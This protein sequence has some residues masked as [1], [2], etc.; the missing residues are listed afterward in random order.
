MF[1]RIECGRRNYLLPLMRLT[2]IKLAGFKS[3]VDPTSIATPGQLIGIVGPNG[4]GKSNVID[5]VRWVLGE[6]SAKQLRG[7]S[8]A[9][10]IFSGSADRKPL[11]RASVELVF[12]NLLGRLSGPW[13]QYTE[14]SVKRIVTREGDSSY[15]IN[16]QHV[17]RKDVT[18]LFLGT[19]LG[20]RS[21]AI[22]EQ[23]MIS[24]V[25][26]AKPEE[27]R[28]FLEEAAGVSKYRERRRETESRLEDTREN[29]SRVADILNELDQ[30]LVKLASQAEVAAKFNELSGDLKENQN[31]YT[32]TRAREA[33]QARERYANEVSKIGVAI[34]AEMAKLR[35]TERLLT[36]LRESH[37]GEVEKLQGLQGAMF[38]ANSSVSQLQQEL[39][40]LTDNRARLT[41]QVEKLA[42]EAAR[43]GMQFTQTQTDNA[44]WSNEL[45][46]SAERIETAQMLAEEKHGL[47]PAAEEAHLKSQ[48]AAK[49]AEV[50]LR[51]AEQAQ[52]MDEMREGQA[53]KNIAQF[54]GRRNR[55]KTEM[56][57][58]PTPDPED[59]AQLEMKREEV[60]EQL[61]HLMDE[62]QSIEVKLPALERDR[63]EQQVRMQDLQREIARMDASLMALEKQQAKLESNNQVA[64]WA[65][66]HGIADAKKLYQHLQVDKGWE[67]TVE[68]ALGN[69]LSATHLNSENKLAELSQ[70]APP[71]SFAAYVAANGAANTH[72][73][74]SLAPLASK[75]T[76]QD[77]ATRAFVDDILAHQFVLPDGMGAQQALAKA[78][79]LPAGSALVA[80]NG[81]RFTRF[82]ASFYGPDDGNRDLHGVLARSREIE[83]I[84]TELPEKQEARHT[85]EEA[86]QKLGQEIET[87]RNHVKTVRAQIG[88]AK[89]KERTIEVELTRLQQNLAVAETRRNAIKQELLQI[90]QEESGEQT[91]IKLA[92]EALAESAVGMETIVN[93]LDDAD[94]AVRAAVNALND[95]RNAAQQAERAAQESTYAERSCRDK[96][97]AI[98]TLAASLTERLAG[99]NMEH[100]HAKAQLDEMNEGNVREQLNQ[101]LLK[102]DER[103][104]ILEDAKRGNEELEHTLRTKDEERLMA[105]QAIAPLN[106]KLSDIRFK[107]Q[108]AR[109]N[110]ETFR[111]QLT[112]A[113]GDYAALAE[114]IERKTR[115]SSLQQ[116]ITRLQEEI[117]AL[118]AVNMAAL[119]E[120]DAA[121]QRKD[122]LDAQALDLNQA[123]ETLENAIRKID[124]ET[125]DLLQNTFDTVNS[126]LKELFPAIFRGGMAY[127]KLTGDEILNAGVEV[128]AQ[129]PGK[130]NQSIQLLS[131]GEK[132]L[133]AI[134][135]VFSLFRLNPA[136]FCML[137]EVDAP[138]DDS[139]TG[140]MADLVRKM[141]DQTQFLFI[142]HNKITME[143]ATQ[144][145]GVT[146]QEPGV[147]R[148]VEVDV[149]AAFEFSQ[150][151]QAAA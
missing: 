112:E 8:M 58:L 70:D 103:K 11:G 151:Q 28:L 77:A 76:T 110:E 81:H 136:P 60:L 101:A 122:F 30:Q 29:L 89:G 109:I 118:G 129:P 111:T 57:S 26:T 49:Q 38:E 56:M 91:A 17:R 42:D 43:V 85:L 141:S 138:L 102:L 149:S 93:R 14:I 127:L 119:E 22:I 5:A 99:M 55:L 16:S 126:Y 27:L 59:I 40:Y 100:D 106:Q 130:K 15:Y 120:L 68:A 35:E 107:E 41:E 90:E 23:G 115:S 137:D 31:L 50:A 72:T 19:G 88:E 39:K 54:E 95:A 108:E 33:G 4:C 147:S 124:K 3:F 82:G 21:Y 113:G 67:D 148:I 78:R 131:G 37:Y 66:K 6:S 1:V 25:I 47:I 71:G 73:S 145:V 134:A 75:V 97:T 144:L 74:S 84:K 142:T 125:R 52:R 53:L 140:R 10:V 20:P 32:F 9:D 123:V 44:H 46:M 12:D 116:D 143:L 133:T 114:L 135:L 64:L 51:E 132:A 7:E 13:A 62:E 80:A 150:K 94:K 104:K 63:Q 79:E 146:M 34:E 24:R 18:D 2:H 96:L 98:A 83:T 86:I 117:A 92:Q 65:S 105:E 139:N 48:E 87:L 36:E 61:T 69:A 45:T 121:K 128:V